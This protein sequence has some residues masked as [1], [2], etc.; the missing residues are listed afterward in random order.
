MSGAFNRPTGEGDFAVAEDKRKIGPVLKNAL[1]RR[2]LKAV[3]SGLAY[4]TSGVFWEFWVVVS[5]GFW[6]VAETLGIVKWS[7]VGRDF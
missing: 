5:W 7:A 1:E 4:G 6:N 2:M 3:E